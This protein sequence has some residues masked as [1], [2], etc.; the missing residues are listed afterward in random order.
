MIRHP[1]LY[2]VRRF[3]TETLSLHQGDGVVVG[4]SRGPDST[5]LTM[6]LQTW[7][8]SLGFRLHAVYIDH[9]LRP[10]SAAEGQEFLRFAQAHCLSSEVAHITVPKQASLQAAAREAR[11]QALAQAAQR[12]GARWIA[13]G[14]TQDDHAETIL[15]R[16]LGHGSLRSLTGIPKVRVLSG[17]L[18]LIRPLWQVS[19][20]QVMDFLHTR[21]LSF[22]EDPSNHNPRYLR[23]RVRQALIPL[24]HTLA[25]GWDGHLQRLSEELREDAD[26]LDDWAQMAAEEWQAQAHL[27]KDGSLAYPVLALQQWPKALALRVLALLA[28][29]SLGHEGLRQLWTLCQSTQGIHG[30]HLPQGWQARRQQ[31]DLWF[32]HCLPQGE[33]L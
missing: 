18:Q 11:Y 9:G 16:L 1:L 15:L 29:V 3:L 28:P 14:H 13:V 25:P 21:Q 12:Q 23:T 2:A 8:P 26:C 10:E 27:R 31:D 6:A 7:A 33:A 17:D 24:L 5:A 20:Q 30:L 32:E 19:R 22:L 4:C